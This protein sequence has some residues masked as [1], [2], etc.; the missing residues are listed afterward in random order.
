MTERNKCQQCAVRSQSL[1]NTIGSEAAGDLARIVHRLRVPEGRIIYGDHERSKTYSIIVSGVVKLVN[2]RPDGRHQI[3][4]LQFPG[5]FV[6]RPY[7]A[8]SNLTAEAATD[9]ELCSFSGRVFEDL[10]AKHA[11]LERALLQRILLDL[12]AAREWMFLLG[13]KSA[14]EK[15]STFLSMIHDKMVL[16]GSLEVGAQ[17][18][19]MIPL[20][21]SRTEISE[22]LSLRLETVSRQFSQLKSRG[23]IETS[24]RRQFRIIDMAALRAYSDAQSV[25]A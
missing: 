15:V 21:L 24:G 8:T 20:P 23:I 14:E 13:S 10:L 16:S 3:A 25:S 5:D 22:C 12:D 19:S 11:E 18:Q 1:C 9:L 7:A 17:G 6:G 4:G 2:T